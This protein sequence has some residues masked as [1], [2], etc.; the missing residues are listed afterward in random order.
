MYSEQDLRDAVLAGAISQDSAEALR[1]HVAQV[2]AM[3]AVDEE[4]Y[5]LINSFNDIFVTIAAVLLLVAMGGVGGFIAPGVGGVLVAASAWGMAEFFTRRRRMALPSIMLLLAFVGGIM[6]A[7]LGVLPSAGDP[8]G[9]GDLGMGLALPGAFIFAALGAW[10]HWRRFRVPITVAAGA[11]ALAGSVIT[12]M[13]IGVA[14]INEDLVT[15]LTLP[16]VFAT[17][18]AVF[19][20]AMWWDMS[21]RTRKTRRSD[22]AFWLHLLAAPLIAHPLFLWLGVL[23]GET[24]GMGG[25]L[26]VLLVYLVFGLVA[27]A[28]D[29]RALL[30]SALG[31]VLCALGSLFGEFGVVELSVALTALV[32]GSALLM[33]SALWPNI[34]A[35]VLGLLPE[36]LRDRLPTS[37]PIP[38]S[39]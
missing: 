26:A 29:R 17:G 13:L 28:V 6:S 25:A 19:A 35:A 24:V 18:L 38:Q 30:V 15:R 31:Y 11:A 23:D 1:S 2:R 27:L 36:N 37:G 3:P 20:Y 21:D 34:R 39:A 33:L 10:L 9:L 4:N 16:L 12:L 14:T 32:I 22:V 7:V 5:R 8:G